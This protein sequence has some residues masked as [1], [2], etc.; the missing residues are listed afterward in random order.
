MDTKCG[1]VN[2]DPRR[3]DNCKGRPVPPRNESHMDMY[4][5]LAR[6]VNMHGKPGE[7]KG[8]KRGQ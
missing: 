1:C 4:R 3:L 2:C 8:K 5:R 7:P 6:I